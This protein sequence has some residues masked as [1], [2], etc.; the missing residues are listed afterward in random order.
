MS[1]MF[2]VHKS[3]THK[4][5]YKAIAGLNKYILH[6][7]IK[8]PKAKEALEI[9]RHFEE[10]TR[11]PQILGVLD[12]THIP[13]TPCPTMVKEFTNTKKYASFV[14]QTITDSNLW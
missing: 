13:C 8:M 4:M 1:T 7:E 5:F 12:Y 2:G 6:K 3:T 9:S 10:R 11:I 14:L